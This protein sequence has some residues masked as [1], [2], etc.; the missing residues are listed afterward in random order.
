ME[1][2]NKVTVTRSGGI[3]GERRR[4]K[5]ARNLKPVW[6]NNDSKDGTGEHYV[7]WNKPDGERQMPYELTYK[8]NLINKT[9]KQAK[10]NQR[11]WNKEQTDSNQRGGGK[12]DNKGKK[13]KG[14][15][16]TCIKDTWTKPKRGRI[17]RGRERTKFK[18]SFCS[19][20]QCFW[21]YFACLFVLFIR[22]HLQ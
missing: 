4:R 12:E 20:F 17:K 13:G 19:L 5:R 2:K 7:K 8:W 21:L 6:K 22:F 3:A 11:H 9:N 15:Q 10:Y 16:G 14:H 18:I 1:I